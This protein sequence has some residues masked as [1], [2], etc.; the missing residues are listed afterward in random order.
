MSQSSTTRPVDPPQ[1]V[2][3]WRAFQE[4]DID[5]ARALSSRLGWPHR[6]EDWAT[7][8]AIGEGVAVENAEGRLVGTGFC[9]NQGHMATLGLVII[10]DDWQGRGLGREMMTRLMGLVGER[11]L[12]LVATEAG[13]PLYIKLGF[14]PCST[15]HQYQGHVTATVNVPA[16]PGMRALRD[17]DRELITAMAPLNPVHVETVR[18]ADDGV[19]IEEDGHLVGV[20]LR[21]LYGRGDHIGPV[22]AQ[23]PER[24]RALM[25]FLLSRAHGRFVR[26]DLVAPEDDRILLEAGLACVNRVERMRRGPEIN[27][28]P[29][30]RFGLINQ[31]L[32]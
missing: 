26:L 17:S 13:A 28:G 2:F 31:A 18:Q 3:N 20:A 14:R 6:H 4:R 8:L 22:M 10:D 29:L 15:I 30:T 11:T 7:S 32:G 23:T 12:Q 21:R 16:I 25:A 1:E 19:V 9:F 24:A 5:A 27:D